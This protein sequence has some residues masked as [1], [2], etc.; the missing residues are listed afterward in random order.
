VISETILKVGRK[1]E[2]YTTKEIREAVGIKP[3]GIVRATVEGS[4]LVIEPIPS[5]E[6]LI[7]DKVIELTP[8]EAEK[9][10][11]ELQRERGIYG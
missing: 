5:I 1:G 9:I 4:K 6:D 7:K 2:I 3:G 10:S 11:E 8:D